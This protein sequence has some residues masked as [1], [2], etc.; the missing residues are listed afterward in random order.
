MSN[1]LLKSGTSTSFEEV[2]KMLEEGEVLVASWLRDPQLEPHVRA[3]TSEGDFDTI[4]ARATGD[5]PYYVELKFFAAPPAEEY[6]YFDFR[7]DSSAMGLLHRA[8]ASF[9]PP[10]SGQS[11]MDLIS[12]LDATAVHEEP[13]SAYIPPDDTGWEEPFTLT[14]T[15]EWQEVA[16]GVEVLRSPN[17]MAF[18]LRDPQ[19]REWGHRLGTI[20]AINWREFTPGIQVRQ[21]RSEP[22]RTEFRLKL[23]DE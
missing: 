18:H 20:E 17:T 3:V 7:P 11:L 13:V 16:P 21:S 2:N 8:I 10:K 22:G 14:L 12:E 23:K 6:D 4:V 1:R 9:D 15:N 5:D 19:T